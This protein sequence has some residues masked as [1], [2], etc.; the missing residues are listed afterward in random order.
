M[1]G[2]QVYASPRRQMLLCCHVAR[3]L[4]AQVSNFVIAVTFV[5]LLPVWYVKIDWFIFIFTYISQ[6]IIILLLMICWI[7]DQ[8]WIAEWYLNRLAYYIFKCFFLIVSWSIHTYI[9]EMLSFACTSTYCSKRNQPCHLLSSCLHTRVVSESRPMSTTWPII[10][11]DNLD[12]G[13][14][15]Y[16][17]NIWG[18]KYTCIHG[19]M[20][21]QFGLI[22]WE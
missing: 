4:G 8:T 15:F 12:L 13:V 16:S 19:R 21:F 9:T 18:N 11:P 20:Y 17:E 14:W 7:N 22:A 1:H 2:N 10:S 6:I 3:L 5:E